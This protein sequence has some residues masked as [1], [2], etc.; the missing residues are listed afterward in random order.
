MDWRDEGILLSVTDHG[1]SSAIIDVLTC[2][3]GRH[4]GLVRG[5]QGSKLSATLQP[6]TELALEWRARLEEHLGNY[7]VEPIKARAAQLMEDRAALAAFGAMSALIIAFVPERQPDYELYEASHDLLV[8][9]AERPRDWPGTYVRWEATFL[10]LMGFGV[11]LSA[12]AA[13]GKRRDLAYVSP[14][15]GRAV[16]REAGGPFADKL[17]PLP[18]FL[19]GEGVVTMAGVRSGMQMTG[20]FLENRLSPALERDAP[21]PEARARL[22]RQFDRMELP[23]RTSPQPGTTLESP[24]DQRASVWNRRLGTLRQAS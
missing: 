9:L 7:R 1:E 3:R 2:S 6:G 5:G 16:S 18:S 14:R 13:T 20:W 22:L 17:L 23:S 12:C 8:D 19:A 11:D 4:P 10:G 21:L 24:I 15:T